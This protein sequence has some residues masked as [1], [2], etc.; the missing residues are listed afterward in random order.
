MSD[1]MGSDD[2]SGQL[3]GAIGGEEGYEPD[4][5]DSGVV[6]EEAPKLSAFAQNYLNTVPDAERD[7]VQ[8]HVQSWDKGFSKYA[9]NISRKY[10]QYDQLGEFEQV[11]QAVQL[12]QLITQ[13]PRTATQWL[14]SQGYGPQEAANAVQGAQQVANQQ[15][16]PNQQPQQPQQNQQEWMPPAVQRELQQYKMALGA[17]NQRFEQDQFNKETERY[18]REIESGLAAV[19]SQ[20][21]QIPET[22]ILHLMKGGM[23]MDDAVGLIVEQIQAGV[24]QRQAP[25]APKVLSSASL[26]PQAAKA[27]SE[28]TDDER[29]AS[30][31]AALQ[32]AME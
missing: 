29:K 22:M 14:L 12:A 27:P 11:Q 20:Y 3:S 9:E 13:D 24:N 31:L 10:G 15:P 21:P 1:A 8:R 19:R 4:P 16:G 30:L 28:M 5:G 23:E 18:Q 26:P 32:G 2:L 7:I 6:Q 25:N 17:M